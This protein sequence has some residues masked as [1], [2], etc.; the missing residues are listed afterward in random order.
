M[1]ALIKNSDSVEVF[2]L[3][4]LKLKPKTSVLVS[5]LCRRKWGHV[6]YAH[7]TLQ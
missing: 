3:E 2:K 4:N 6:C 5:D 1:F 7:D